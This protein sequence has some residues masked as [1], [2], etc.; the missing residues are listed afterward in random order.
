MAE[1]ESKLELG[2]LPLLLG[3]VVAG[4]LAG[5]YAFRQLE[6][7]RFFALALVLVIATGTASLVAGLV[8]A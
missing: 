5:A 1:G 3:L 7:E 2:E 6:H 8:G 4:Y